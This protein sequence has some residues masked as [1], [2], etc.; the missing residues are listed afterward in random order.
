MGIHKKTSRILVVLLLLALCLP[1]MVPAMEVRAAAGTV[2]SVAISNL[3]AKT[4]TLKKGKTFKLKAKVTVK[5]KVSKA[6]TF[7]TSNKKVV[8]VTKAGKLTAKKKGTAKITVTSKAN[9]KKKVVIKVTVGVPVTKIALDR[10]SAS[11]NI[12]KTLTL[13]AAPAPAKASNKKVI[14]SSDKPAI[15]AVSKA[16]V[17]TAKSAG[18]ANIKCLAA[19]GSG[20]KAF[21]KVTVKAEKKKVSAEE[22][23][24]IL[25]KNASPLSLNKSVSVPVNRESSTMFKLTADQDGRYEFNVAKDIPDEIVLVELYDAS[26]ASIDWADSDDDTGRYA[27]DLS[28]GRTYYISLFSSKSGMSLT[29]RIIKKVTIKLY[30]NGGYF[31]GDYNEALGGTEQLPSFTYSCW[32]GEKVWQPIDYPQ[33]EDQSLI[34]AGYATTPTAS[35]SECVDFPSIKAESDSTYYAI[36][37]EK[38]EVTFAANNGYFFKDEKSGLYRAM[39]TITYPKGAVLTAQFPN[40]YIYFQDPKRDNYQFVGWA[41]SNTAGPDE[42]ID[43][44]KTYAV[45]GAKYYAVWK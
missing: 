39:I 24:E 16:G 9:K 28:K 22:E 20:K 10:A 14:W 21:C 35:A 1:S 6:V 34:L 2:K 27:A 29:A 5:G 4:L 43:L 32:Q 31:S 8:T 45:D 25:F 23:M 18:T 11:L 3:P 40:V 12:G 13:K 17:V 19:D 38:A 26:K 42:I 7:K 44:D 33:H 41:V 36:W 30:A 37:A 15:A